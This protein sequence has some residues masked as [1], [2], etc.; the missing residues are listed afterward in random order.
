MYLKNLPRSEAVVLETAFKT[1]KNPREKLRFQAVWLL[2]QGYTRAATANIVAK[3]KGSLGNW[4]A[5]FNRSGLDGLKNKPSPKN[6]RLLTDKHKDQIARLITTKVPT[7]LGIPGSFWSVP[8]LKLLV[9]D[10]LGV[11]Y[12]SPE[13]YRQLMIR[14]GFS[15]HQPEKRNCRK[16]PHLV[17][18]F[19]DKLKK[20]SRGTSAKMVWYW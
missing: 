13:S 6:H 8:G 11:V 16:Q 18:R 10:K 19:E 3:S 20:D 1:A 17:K 9:K 12:R 5:A 4:V 14:C 2:T 15:Y 7:D